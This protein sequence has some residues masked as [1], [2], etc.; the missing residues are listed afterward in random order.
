MWYAYQI[1]INHPNLGV[2]KIKLSLWI[3]NRKVGFDAK[4]ASYTPYEIS[5]SP[6]KLKAIMQALVLSKIGKGMKLVPSDW[7]VIKHA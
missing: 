3:Y 5:I 4:T 2:G 6:S 1:L 7:G